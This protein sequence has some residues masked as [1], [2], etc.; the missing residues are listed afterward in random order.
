[1]TQNP[2]KPFILY[3]QWWPADEPG[4]VVAGELKYDPD[5]GIRLSMIGTH[6]GKAK[7]SKAFNAGVL[8]DV[9]HGKTTDGQEVTLFYCYP[10]QFQTS[11]KGVEKEEYLV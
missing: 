2:Y 1:M 4:N 9:L 5:S 11:A 10:I 7:A 8:K 6:H 3:G